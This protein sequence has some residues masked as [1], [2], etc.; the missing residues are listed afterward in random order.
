MLDLRR[1]KTDWK[2]TVKIRCNGGQQGLHDPYNTR[3]KYDCLSNG[4]RTV[5]R[6]LHQEQQLV[7]Q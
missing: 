7:L 2:Y 5:D 3:E 4:L 1:G 6:P